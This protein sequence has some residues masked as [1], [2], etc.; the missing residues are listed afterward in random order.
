MWPRLLGQKRHHSLFF[1][2]I[3]V[4]SGSFFRA[5]MEQCAWGADVQDDGKTPLSF[6]F[7]LSSGIQW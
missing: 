5:K 7:W 4:F 1:L 2:F 6:L 3:A